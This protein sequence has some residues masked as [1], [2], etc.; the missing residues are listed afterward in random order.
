VSDLQCAATLLVC[1]AGEAEYDGG[2]ASLTLAGRDR[3]RKLGESLGSA[4]IAMVYTSSEPAA[5]QTAELAAATGGLVVRVRDGLREARPDESP[6][7]DRARIIEELQ[8]IVDLHRGETVLVVSHT[9]AVHSVV[10]LLA[11]NL[12]DDFVAGHEPAPCTVTE[13]AVD[14]DGWLV[15]SWSGAPV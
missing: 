10:P 14:G 12:P 6:E 1:C 15:R 13:V 4:R 9:G 11:G 2:A 5:V 7:Q 3:A 8:G